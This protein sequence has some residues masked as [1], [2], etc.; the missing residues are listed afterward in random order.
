MVSEKIL[1]IIILT[2]LRN[3]AN[4]FLSRLA[5]KGDCW[6][7]FWKTI[8]W[9]DG[10]IFFLTPGVFFQACDTYKLFL[11]TKFAA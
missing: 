9:K 8:P 7:S 3:L 1:P 5:G 11:V 6:P 10:L 4:A 2:R